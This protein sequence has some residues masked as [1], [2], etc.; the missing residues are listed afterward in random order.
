MQGPALTIGPDTPLVDLRRI[1]VEKRIHG[2]PVVD[3]EGVLLGVVSSSDLLASALETDDPAQPRPAAVDYL[4]E[5][6]ELSPEETRDMASDLDDGL[7]ARTAGD[8][9]TRGAT[10]VDIDAPVP[11]VARA[12]VKHRI[13][14]V[15][16]LEHGR[17]CGIISSLDLVAELAGPD[18]SA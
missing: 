6:F 8:I 9:M 17:V 10:S 5:L 11:E 16:V 18:P 13:H 12:L 15:V 7:G 2:V 4:A 3:R 14:R 1:F